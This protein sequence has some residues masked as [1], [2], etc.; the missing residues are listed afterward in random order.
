MEALPPV[1][2][3]VVRLLSICPGMRHALLT[4][5]ATDDGGAGLLL[6]LS[7]VSEHH[8]HARKDGTAPG[9]HRNAAALALQVHTLLTELRR[10]GDDAAEQA[11]VALLR[12][13]AGADGADAV[14]KR[15]AMRLGYGGSGGATTAPL[16]AQQEEMAAARRMRIPTY[17]QAGTTA[18]GNCAGCRRLRR[19]GEGAFQKCGRC[20]VTPY[21]S[22]A[23]QAAHWKTHKLSC[24]A[25]PGTA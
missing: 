5:D 20:K 16:A 3:L 4:A 7:T 14:R 10:G 1:I 11:T 23:C 22:R 21:C 19:A 12:R 24:T 13:V 2:D 15:L 17:C 9:K 25:A 6:V 18:A 8:P